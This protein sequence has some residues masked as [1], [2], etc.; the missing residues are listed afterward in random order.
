MI[1]D[2]EGEPARPLAERRP[3]QSPLKDVAGMMRSFSYAA[4]AALF[5]FTVHAPDAFGTLEPGPTTWEHWVV[6]GVRD[7]NTAR[8]WPTRRLASW[9]TTPRVVLC[10]AFVLDKALYELAYELNT[11][12]NGSASRLPAFS[13]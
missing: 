3:K 11:G 8:R 1:L 2:F 13:S 9:A 6:T 7:A 10:R 12:P 4:Y 5:A